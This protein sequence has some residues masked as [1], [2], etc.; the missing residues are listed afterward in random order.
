[1]IAHGGKGL[2]ADWIAA[3]PAAFFARRLSL[4]R[5]KRPDPSENADMAAMMAVKIDKATSILGVF[6]TSERG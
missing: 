1:M 5:R 3:S 6:V 2:L 4:H